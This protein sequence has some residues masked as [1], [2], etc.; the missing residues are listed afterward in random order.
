[1]LG[2]KPCGIIEEITSYQWEEPKP[3][4]ASRERPNQV[5]DHGLDALRYGC[6]A[7]DRW[8]DGEAE[9][10]KPAYEEGTIGEALGLNDEEEDA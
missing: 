8:F 1:M 7:I 2:N 9:K 3:D 4:K 6:L 5:N 10:D